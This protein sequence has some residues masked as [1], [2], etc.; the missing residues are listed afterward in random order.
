[1]TESVTKSER[2]FTQYFHDLHDYINNILPA[3]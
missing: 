3:N 1:M 2:I